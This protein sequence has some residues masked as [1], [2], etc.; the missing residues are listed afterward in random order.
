M[1]SYK[2]IANA[3]V[4][5][6]DPY[7]RS[8]LYDL[9][10]RNDRIVQVT[11]KAGLLAS[12]YPGATMIDASNKIV[13]PG[14][15][16][17]HFHSESV[18]L[19]GHTDN[20]HYSLWNT[21]PAIQGCLAGFM[22]PL[23]KDIIRN[24]YLMSYFRHLKSGTT[25][26]SE[27][28]LPFDEHGF[29]QMLHAIERTEV[30]TCV[31]LQ[32]W[33]QISGAGRLSNGRHRFFVNVGKE[34]EFTVYSFENLL[35][36]ARDLNV[37]LLAHV[38]EQRVNAENVRR[39]FQK[40]IL[41]VL[42]DFGVVQPET[43]FVHLNH[44][45]SQEAEALAEA[46]A[47]VI[48]CARSAALKR[49]GYPLLRHLTRERIRLAVGTDWANTDMLEELKFLLHL[50]L[51]IPDVPQLS[52]LQLLRMG[53][54]NGAHALGLSQDIGSIEVGKKADLTFYSLGDLRLPPIPEDAN[55]ETLS[56]LLVNHMT[57]RDVSDVMINGEFYVARGEV[58]TMAE[59]EILEGYRAASSQLFDSTAKAGP[60]AS[61]SGVKSP[62]P[63]PAPKVLPFSRDGRL[64]LHKGEGFESGFRV[65]EPPMPVTGIKSD[66]TAVKQDPPAAT[67][68]G[69]PDNNGKGRWRTF[70]EEDF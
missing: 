16:N 51:L 44:M 53:T 5:T 24:V 68:S 21:N 62:L 34:D 60:P 48:V 18:L 35:R 46:G 47:T 2:I 23:N 9:L 70:G 32:N 63:G 6:C 64:S 20:L 38:A 29:A 33:D 57:N 55:A 25:C 49:T 26:V 11:D 14:F 54:I 7:N 10:I 13:I 58:M 3:F 22:D 66:K 17:A 40:G 61:A 65:A 28:A 42:K 8:G 31:A 12:L 52:P 56:S 15:V 19:S 59:E 27:Y 30:K 67:V 41:A 1:D 69:Q 36:A 39:T 37:P 50:H 4:I 45:S 43:V